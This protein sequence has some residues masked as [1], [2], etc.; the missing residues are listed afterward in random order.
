MAR[1]VPLLLIGVLLGAVID[2]LRRAEAAPYRLEARARQHRETIEINDS[3]V[4]GLSA[5]KWSLEAG[6]AQ[7][8]LT[9]APLWGQLAAQPILCRELARSG[10]GFLPQVL[11][12]K[13]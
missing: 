11:A 9:I 4:Q 7:D 12:A 10:T 1:L 6:N 13:R 3:I 2:H 5:I 8:A